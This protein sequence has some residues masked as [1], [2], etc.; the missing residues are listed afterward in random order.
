MILEFTRIKFLFSDQSLEFM[1]KQPEISKGTLFLPF[2]CCST[3]DRSLRQSRVRVDFRCFFMVVYTQIPDFGQWNSRVILYSITI[4]KLQKLNHWLS[5]FD[6]DP[7]YNGGEWCEV[8]SVMKPQPKHWPNP[9]SNLM[10]SS[11]KLASTL[12]FL[13]YAKAVFQKGQKA[14][15]CS[16]Q[17]MQSSAVCGFC[18]V[19]SSFWTEQTFTPFQF[20]QTS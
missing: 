8:L 20:H 15:Q 9:L 6:F 1:C 17:Y 19:T 10:T 2:C 4:T 16:V 14:R 11:P 3:D 5:V 12:F 7:D 13:S 18:F